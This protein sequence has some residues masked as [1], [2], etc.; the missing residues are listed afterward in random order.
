MNCPN[1]GN[2]YDGNPA[3]CSRCGAPLSQYSENANY[4]GGCQSPIQSR[5][6]AVCVI[7]SIVTC[8]I[9]GIYWF[10]C[11]VNDLNYVSDHPD[12]T[13]GGVVFLL[14]LITCGIYGI[15]WFYKAGEKVSYIKSRTTG[16]PDSSTGI[17]YLILALL[18]LQIINYC[19]IQNELNKVTEM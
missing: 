3:F 5:N 14:S 19:L 7:L 13:S 11:M 4:Y 17:L 2:P 6:I 15:Y 8:G 12:D 16:Y 10:I 18:G 9:Y 1:C